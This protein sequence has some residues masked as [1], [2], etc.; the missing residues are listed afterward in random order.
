MILYKPVTL[1]EIGSQ[2]PP[3]PSYGADNIYSYENLP[4][5]HHKKYIYASRFVKLVRAKTPKVT[6]YTQRAKCLFMEN[7]PHP[8]CEVHF[9]N[10]LKVCAK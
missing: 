1:L 9:Y 5:R 10:G 6:L 3:L 8:D 2:P 7:G 4:P